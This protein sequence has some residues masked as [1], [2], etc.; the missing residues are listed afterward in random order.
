MDNYAAWSREARA[1]TRAALEADPSTPELCLK[2]SAGRFGI[3][4]CADRP[5][6]PLRV[7]DRVSGAIHAYADVE[8][9]IVA[10]WVL[11]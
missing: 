5:G 10:G 7:V 9:L 4:S 8:A 1:R 6:G 3:L 11:D 2:H